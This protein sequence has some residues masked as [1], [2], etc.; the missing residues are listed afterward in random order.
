M[1]QKKDR[2]LDDAHVRLEDE[3]LLQIWLNV[4]KEILFFGGFQRNAFELV[5]LLLD[6]VFHLVAQLSWELVM[7]PEF[8]DGFLVVV[9]LFIFFLDF[10]NG[11]TDNVDHVPENGGSNQLN[12]HYEENF[13]VVLRC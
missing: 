8:V 1:G 9:E 10:I 12:Y 4:L 6:V 5:F 11:D 7:I 3:F 2:F 13:D